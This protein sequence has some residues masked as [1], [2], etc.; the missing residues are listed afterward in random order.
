MREITLR[1]Q[2]PENYNTN[3]ASDESGL[4]TGTEGGA[5]QNFKDECDINTILARFKIGYEMPAGIRVPQYG[6]FTGINDFHTAANAIAKARE[7]F[8]QLPAPVRSKFENDPGKF[9]DFATNEE[10]REE[11]KKMGLLSKEAIQRD[12]EA[13]KTALQ[14]KERVAQAQATASPN[15]APAQTRSATPPP[16]S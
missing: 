5:Q 11:L 12:A 1:H 6:D 4:D 16:K 7:A 8:D 2:F 15:A 9:V 3:E 10:N 14:E 13:A